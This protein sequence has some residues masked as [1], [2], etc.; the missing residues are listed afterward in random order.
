MRP[1]D[2]SEVLRDDLVTLAR[3][4][5][6]SRSQ[7]V[8]LFLRRLSKRYHASLPALCEQ[9]QALLREAP[10]RSSPLRKEAIPTIPVDIDSRLKLLRVE[11]TPDID[12]D[13]IYP[14]HIQDQLNQLLLERKR[15]QQLDQAGLTPS[16]TVLFTGPPGVGKTLAAR[17]LA[18]EL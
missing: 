13:P 18:R 5:L 16:R 9:L 8:H 6:T 1:V 7:D 2:Q 3:L 4:A 14:K 17:W 10:T 12:T 11:A 15:L